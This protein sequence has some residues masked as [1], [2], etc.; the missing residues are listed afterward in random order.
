MEISPKSY[1]KGE[2]MSLTDVLMVMIAFGGFILN[3]INLVIIIYKS[4]ADKK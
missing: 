4:F 1:R 3:L 2:Q